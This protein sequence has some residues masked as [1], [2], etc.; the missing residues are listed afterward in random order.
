MATSHHLGLTATLMLNS[1]KPVIFITQS[2]E[3]NITY[4][5]LYGT[6]LYASGNVTTGSSCTL[7]S[8]FK[9]V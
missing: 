3:S 7:A 5:G 2:Q 1:N 6:V 9:N 8:L 4:K